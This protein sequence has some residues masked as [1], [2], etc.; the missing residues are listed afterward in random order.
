MTPIKPN[1]IEWMQIH[2]SSNP[3]PA[4]EL[5]ARIHQALDAGLTGLA[6]VN[7][8]TGKTL[9]ILAQN[10]KVRQVYIRN[11]RIPVPNWELSLTLQGEGTVE[12]HP[13]PSRAL[14]F[15]K[16]ILEELE[17]PKPQPSGTSQLKTMFD[18]AE[19]NAS[20]TLFHIQWASAEGFVLVAGR[21][22]PLRHAVLLTH[23]GAEEAQVALDHIPA[24][25]EAQCLV[26]VY[27]ANIMNQAWFEIHLNILLEWYCQTILNYYGQLTGTVMVRS[28]L[29]SVSVLAEINH[30]SISTKDNRLKDVSIFATAAE[31][32]NAYRE[33]LSTIKSRIEPIVGS[34]LTQNLMK[35]TRDSAKDIY[36]SIQEI[37]GLIG[38]V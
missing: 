37:F 3:V 23:A 14:M 34:S 4:G 15:R 35:Q 1:K 25:E 28:I 18:L 19:R 36:K 5:T 7:F 17:T 29:Q 38:E 9:R 8:Q 16:I 27:R 13:M 31:A 10:G 22:I 6:L 26:T 20:P 11:H 2:S 21:S 24:W 30:W 33:I 32:G 12:I